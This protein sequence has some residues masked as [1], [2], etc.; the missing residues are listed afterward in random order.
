MNN[1]T[2]NDWLQCG[3][4]IILLIYCL[5]WIVMRIRRRKSNCCSDS[6]CSSG[7]EGCGLADKCSRKNHNIR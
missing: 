5:V 1:L 2:L 6:K 3:A 7:C 4:V